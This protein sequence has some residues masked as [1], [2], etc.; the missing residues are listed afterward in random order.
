MATAGEHVQI[1]VDDGEMR[2]FLATP[3]GDGPTPAIILV[4]DIMGLAP[5]PEGV[6]ARFAEE[7]YATLVPDLFWKV[8]LPAEFTDRESFMRFRRSLNDDDMLRSL[9]AA[10]DFLAARS[11]V[12]GSRIGII[13]YCMGGYY[14]LLETAHNDAIR[15]CADYYGG[16]DEAI[17]YDAG[18]GVRVPFLGLFGE[19]DQSI[20]VERVHEL[21]RIVRANEVDA[22]F[23]IYP[24]AGHAF[25]RDGGPQY[26]EDA[27]QD[28]WKRTVAFFERSLQVPAQSA[29]G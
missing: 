29:R 23:Y 21:E 6:A 15:A 5:H 27:A 20:P 22:E 4:H 18:R 24:G 9:D 8:G 11:V 19:E 7:G 28:A 16:G 1:P 13:G 12:D 26:V 3:P 10:V 17:V 14:A 25:F 2:A